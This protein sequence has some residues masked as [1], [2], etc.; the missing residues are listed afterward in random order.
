VD[1]QSALL[2]PLTDFNNYDDD[3]DDDDGDDG[4][5]SIH[6]ICPR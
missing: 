3:D 2:G 1:T 5:L 6:L 4:P